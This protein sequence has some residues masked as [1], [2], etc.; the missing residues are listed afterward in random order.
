MTPSK[1]WTGT[2]VQDGGETKSEHGAVHP[3]F[4]SALGPS[5]LEL[6]KEE[7]VEKGES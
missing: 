5:A 1:G 4:E 7:A 2:T 3:K 6:S